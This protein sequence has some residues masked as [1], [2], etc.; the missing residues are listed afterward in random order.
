MESCL[1]DAFAFTANSTK[2]L[3]KGDPSKEME[4]AWYGSRK[5]VLSLVSMHMALPCPTIP[6]PDPLDGKGW[7]FSQLEIFC[8]RLSIYRWETEGEGLESKVQSSLWILGLRMV[9]LSM[10]MTPQVLGQLPSLCSKC[11]SEGRQDM[12]LIVVCH[13][14]SWSML[15]S[16]RVHLPV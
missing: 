12:C 4:P 13:P 9:K 3:G 15:A 16:S 1:K 8:S 14:H 11:R 10:P 6:H 7:F 2:E 5:G